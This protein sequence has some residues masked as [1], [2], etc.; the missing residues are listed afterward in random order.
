[1]DLEYEVTDLE[2]VPEAA[3]GFYSQKDGKHVLQVKGVVPE[4]TH[5]QLKTSLNEFRT[6]NTTL[7]K[8]Q[9]K[10]K[11]LASIIGEDGLDPDKLQTRINQ[12]ADQRVTEMKQTYEAEK[13]DL[14]NKYG[15]AAQMLENYILTDAVTK[16]ALKHGVVE[17]ALTDVVNRAKSTFSVT[18]GQV[19]AK[20]GVKNKKGDN[21]SVEDWM[22]SLAESAPHFFG[23][24][25]GAGATRP[26]GSTQQPQLSTHEKLSAAVG[27]LRK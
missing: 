15:Q 17:S 21:L 5:L 2:S 19:A 6:N 25:Q 7:L 16:M 24:T 9:S 13:Q 27:R 1:M 26:V 18:E 20:D 11:A 10:F 22:S 3:R 14:T 4:A 12:L 23:K 8:E